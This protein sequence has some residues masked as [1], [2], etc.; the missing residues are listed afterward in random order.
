MNNH[1]LIAINTQLDAFP[2]LPEI[3]SRVMAVT[4]NP[5]SDVDDLVSVIL[6]D[7][8][9]CSTILKVAS[10][11]LLGIPKEVS[12]IERA[13]VVLGY[14]EIK[15]IVIGKS[16]FGAFPKMT[17]ENRQALSLFL[18]HAFTCGIAAKV[19]G[20]NFRLSPGELF[21]AGLIHDIGKLALLL[22][23]PGDYS[24]QREV[25]SPD[26]FNIT[27]AETSD[28]SISHDKVGLLLAKRWM[29]PDQLTTAIGYHHSPLKAQS[30]GL[31]PLI[32]QLA[33]LLALIYSSPKITSE[34]DVIYIIED[35]F[36]EIQP[37][38]TDNKLDLDTETLERWYEELGKSR[39]ENQG[40]LSIFTAS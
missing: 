12:T 13:V 29:L 30:H 31:Y 1:N 38:W 39:E 25:S 6:P 17:R 35:I 27:K 33:D 22:T 11:A 20:E 26:H 40:V 18:E 7:Q 14:E 16:I 21:I 24:L 5:D 37:F 2:A 10:S 36:S 19:I 32:V 9:M 34:D 8:T 28:F 3:V 4:A 23:F 15:N